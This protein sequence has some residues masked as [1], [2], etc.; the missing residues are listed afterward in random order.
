M[1][2]LES[3]EF[4]AW[5]KRPRETLFCPGIPGA[6]KTILASVVIDELEARFGNDC[7]VGIAYLFC[8]FEHNDDRIQ[9]PENLLASI[10]RQ[11]AQGIFPMPDSVMALYD[12]HKTKETRSSFNEISKVLQSVV[13]HLSRVFIVVDALDECGTLAISR[14]LDEFF[15]LQQKNNLNLLATSRCIPEIEAR[16][17]KALTREIRAAK[18]DVMIYLNANLKKLP[19][20]VS[21]NQQLQQRIT[22]EITDATGGM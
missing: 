14:I 13:S 16:F 11:L 4:Q 20:F 5:V 6:G 7:D 3:L 18:P 17:P 15:N 8:S 21:R 12:K 1:W 2:F 19:A 9:R 10:L 22:N